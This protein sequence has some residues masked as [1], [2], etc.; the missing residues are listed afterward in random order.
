M[1]NQFIFTLLLFLLVV[2]V[3]CKEKTITTFELVD[4]KYSMIDF[5]ND[6]NETDSFNIVDYLYYYNGG[7]VSIGDLNNDNLPDIVF[8]ANQSSDKIYLNQGELRF[9]DITSNSGIDT[10]SNWSTGVNIVDINGDGWNDIYICRLGKYLQYNDHNRLYINNQNGTFTEKAKDFNLDFQGF[11][12]QAAFF[13]FDR[14]GD[15]DCYLLN[16]SVKNSEQFVPSE[17]RLSHDSLSGDLLLRNDNGYFTD[18]T[19]QMDIYSSTIGFGLGITINDFNLD[20]WPDIYVGNDFHE[21]DYLYLNQEGQSFIEKS[22]ELLGHSSNFTMGV[23]SADINEDEKPDIITLDMQAEN[24]EVYKASGGWE[25]LQIYHFK[26]SYG[27]HFQS[28][29]NTMQINQFD[30][31]NISFSEQAGMHDFSATDWSWSPLISDF[32]GDGKK[33]IYI[34][35]GI[36]KRP[37]D[38]DFVDY[39][40]ESINSLDDDQELINKMPGGEMQNY[41]FLG[42]ENSF[43]KEFFPKQNT[44][45][46]GASFADLDLDGDYDIV[47]NNINSE[48]ML[49]E[50]TLNPE[51]YFFI[52]LNNIAN[53]KNENDLGAKIILYSKGN[54][55]VLSNHLNTG[56]QSSSNQL[57]S[58]PYSI[59]Q[60]DSMRIIWSDGLSS[61]Y[62][63]FNELYLSE[64]KTIY[65]EKGSGELENEYF[66]T[67]I[68]DIIIQDTLPAHAENQFNDQNI[69]SFIPYFLSTNSP[70]VI[71]GREFWF[72]TNSKNA[73]IYIMDNEN[74]RDTLS[75]LCKLAADVNDAV[76]VDLN[77]D[78]LEDIYLGIGGNEEKINN[79][80][81]ADMIFLQKND[82]SFSRTYKMLP[83]IGRNTGSVS[84]GDLD[85]DG[86]VDLFIGV[87]G[88]SG[89]YGE[90]EKSYFLFNSNNKLIPQDTDI[91]ELIFDTE[92]IDIDGNGLKD[93]ISV[94][95]WMPITILSQT[96]EKYYS[97]ILIDNSVGIWFSVEIDDVNLDGQYDILAG[98]FGINHRL[99]HEYTDVTLNVSDFD[100]NNQADPII[101]YTY[102]GK[103]Y[104]FPNFTMM[105][106]QL[107]MIKKK[108]RS[109][110]EYSNAPL[111]EVFENEVLAKAQQKK[112]NTFSSTCFMQS[113]KSWIADI[114]PYEC[115]LA[116]IWDFEKTKESEYLFGGNFYEVDPNWGR[117]D[118]MPLSILKY[119][120]KFFSARSVNPLISGEIRDIE[121]MENEII[122]S[123]NSDTAILILEK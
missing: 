116:P 53:T 100:K 91:E 109:H 70:K 54:K 58:I 101:S 28:P 103:E 89:Q 24:E 35:N 67:I 2:L 105:G 26:N 19:K 45:S 46:T 60:L 66:P 23:A 27:Y 115:Q 122:I 76:I 37:N 18:V 8:T 96:K 71:K 62:K 17:I 38:M 111:S 25:N 123:R 117:Q 78:G 119:H 34:T 50:N 113:G 11:S 21:Q 87:Q 75:F 104:P 14:D 88:V 110:Q 20:G 4:P 64:Q 120:D 84:A 121:K 114:L 30:H 3:S 32:N 97:K 72:H 42:S 80:N 98:N 33:D 47:V 93:V 36:L 16:H 90:N 65:V 73:S 95:H 77:G 108:F 22:E 7:G 56:F 55:M 85:N 69:E 118:A 52:K 49:I 43:K 57:I 99:A 44:I 94:G 31:H 79:V 102:K 13:D 39:M 112:L 29:R 41:L 74:L 81:L 9:K 15:L 40:S 48:S 82:N 6:L 51:E 68:D 106:K 10:S 1:N 83:V 61:F 92:I 63:D 12:T 86:D 107:P 5:R 59:N